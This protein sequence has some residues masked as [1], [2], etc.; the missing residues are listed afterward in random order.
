MQFFILAPN[1]ETIWSTV[2]CE[3]FLNLCS[4]VLTRM[5]A[6]VK[7]NQKINLQQQNGSCAQWPCAHFFH[8]QINQMICTRAVSHLDIICL[9]HITRACLWTHF[10]NLRPWCKL[11]SLSYDTTW[12]SVYCDA[13]AQ[14]SYIALN[15]SIRHWPVKFLCQMRS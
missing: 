8:E 3:L 12:L 1:T 9:Q 6:F 4:P 5:Q 7:Y 14:L 10:L 11:R 13:L 15:F 2:Q